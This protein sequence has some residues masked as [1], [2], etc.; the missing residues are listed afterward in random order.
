MKFTSYYLDSPIQKG[1][2]F[3]V[4][5]PAD[6][7]PERDYAVF[8]VHGGGWRAGARDIYH[9]IMD[10][11][12]R[13]GYICAS[14]DYRL[15]AKDAFE[16]LSDIREAYDKFVGILKARGG[17]MPKIATYGSSAGAHLS[18]LVA[19]AEPGELGED[20]SKLQYPEVRPAKA[21]VQVLFYHYK[22]FQHKNCFL[23]K[24]FLLSQNLNMSLRAPSARVFYIILP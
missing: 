6:G 8:F 9:I 10:E 15:H 7:A 3:D 20:V 11:L 17:K 22:F 5:E 14:T 23:K 1:R 19:F 21:I 16:Q 24:Y 13:R 18:S 2:V 4:F 12:C